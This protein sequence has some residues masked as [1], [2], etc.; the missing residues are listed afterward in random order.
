MP[1]SQTAG[2]AA[3]VCALA[4]I[5]YLPAQRLPFIADDY[6]QI[7]LGRD[8]GPVLS[9]PA[10]LRDPLYRCRA[11]SVVLTHWTE[12]LVGLTPLVF[13]VSSL[14]LHALNALLL[15]FVALRAGADAKQSLFAAG[16]FAV[17]EGHQEAVIWYAALPELLVFLFGALAFLSFSAALDETRGRIWYWASLISFG[18]A[19]ASK[20]SGVVVIA[21]NVFACP[22][23]KTP[24]RR[25]VLMVTPFALLASF[26]VLAIFWSSSQILHF[27]DGAFSLGAPV[28]IT[29]LNSTARILWFWG[30]LA[31]AILVSLNPTALKSTLPATLC[32][33]L[34][35]L[36]PYSFLTYMNRVPSRHTYLAS[37]GLSMMFGSAIA[38]L[39]NRRKYRAVAG[40]LIALAVIHNC[41]YLWT[42]KQAQYERRAQATEELVR[43]YKLGASSVSIE[44]FPY[45]QWIARYAIEIGANKHWD[46][47]VWRPCSGCAPEEFRMIVRD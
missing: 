26:Y 37:V 19:L 33:I 22:V 29:L 27:H 38:V 8:Y 28:I 2:A 25:T 47:G 44:C 30:V 14:V 11:T 20:E 13:H 21:A 9:W 35:A 34:I 6:V 7:Q 12:E 43:R 3:L 39:A 15:W 1:R 42:K 23:R 46:E 36:V 32:W 5:A 31:T 17:A 18:L 4:V 16:F 45:S 41:G 40:G 10:L 24:I